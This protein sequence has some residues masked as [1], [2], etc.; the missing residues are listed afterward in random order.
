M[1]RVD[2]IPQMK[3]KLGATNYM[4]VAQ[5]EGAPLCKGCAFQED[6]DK[7]F[8]APPCASF[9]RIDNTNAIFIRENMK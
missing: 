7:C 1:K 6:S 5:K 3:F 8:Y 9:Q 4:A 2:I